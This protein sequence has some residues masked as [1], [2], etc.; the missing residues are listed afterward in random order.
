[1]ANSQILIL[2]NFSILGFHIMVIINLVA[3][4]YLKKIQY[5]N[6]TFGYVNYHRNTIIFKPS[7]S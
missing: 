2:L 3:I 1:M 7:C 6:I 4:F 5:K